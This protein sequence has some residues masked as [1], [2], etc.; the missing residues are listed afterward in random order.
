M[1]TGRIYL[2]EIMTALD[3]RDLRSVKKWCDIN[4]VRILCD[5]GCKWRYVLMEEF[6]KALTR[7]HLHKP[8]R[9]R[10]NSRVYST[11]YSPQGEYEKTLLSIF[12]NI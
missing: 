4:H 10:K 7:C 1:N 3:Y 9:P 11:S 12:T 2:K 6:E 5:A 8:E